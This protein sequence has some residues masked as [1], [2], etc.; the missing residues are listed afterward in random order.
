MRYKAKSVAALQTL[1]GVCEDRRRASE[2]DDVARESGDN[3]AART[4]SRERH[5]GEQGQRGNARVAETV[6]KRR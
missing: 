5:K 3:D 1:L 4:R 2:G 6:R